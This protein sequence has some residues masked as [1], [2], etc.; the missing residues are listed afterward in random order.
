MRGQNCAG[1]V[2]AQEQALLTYGHETSGNLLQRIHMH[3]IG[4]VELLGISLPTDTTIG[5]AQ[6]QIE[7][8]HY[9][10]GISVLNE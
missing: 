7:G 4:V 8:A 9:R 2:R 5:A 10:Y 6:R 3:P 1:V